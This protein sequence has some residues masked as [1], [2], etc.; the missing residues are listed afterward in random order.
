MRPKFGACVPEACE[1]SDY[2]TNAEKMYDGLNA[3][4]STIIS[5]TRDTMD[6]NSR[7]DTVSYVVM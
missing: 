2:N 6:K 3:K 4:L 1:A 5:H 7:P